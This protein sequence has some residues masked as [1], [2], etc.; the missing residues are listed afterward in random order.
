VTQSNEALAKA[1]FDYTPTDWLLAPVEL[2]GRLP[3]PERL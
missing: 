2:R 3:S 1:S